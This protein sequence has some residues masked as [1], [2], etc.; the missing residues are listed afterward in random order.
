METAMTL[1][2]PLSV[3]TGIGENWGTAH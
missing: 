2:V 3:E 1:S